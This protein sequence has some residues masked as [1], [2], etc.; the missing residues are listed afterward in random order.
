LRKIT[1]TIGKFWLLKILNEPTHLGNDS[2][3]LRKMYWS[4][5]F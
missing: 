3:I 5:D 2:I 1:S 4:D